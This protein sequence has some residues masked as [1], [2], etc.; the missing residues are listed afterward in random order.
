MNK[1]QQ[2]KTAFQRSFSSSF[3]LG[4]INEN[5]GLEFKIGYQVEFI[6]NRFVFEVVKESC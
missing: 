1:I 4:E 3:V 2:K 5:G 6:I